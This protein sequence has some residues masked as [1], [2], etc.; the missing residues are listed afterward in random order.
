LVSFTD[1]SIDD[2]INTGIELLHVGPF[3]QAREHS[4]LRSQLEFLGS[5]TIK[6]LPQFNHEGN[7]YIGLSGVQAN[8]SVCLLF[9][10]AEG[11]AD[12]KLDKADLQWSTLCDNYWKELSVMDFIFDTTNDFLTSGVIKLIIPR[13]ATTD[14][15]IMPGDLIWFKVSIPQSNAV[16]L[17]IDVQSNA[18]IAEFTDQGNDPN[19]LK[20]PLAPN[21]ISKLKQPAGAIKGI[22][23]PYTSFGGRMQENDRA[24]YTRVSERLRHKERTITSWDYERLIL[25]HFPS[26]YKVKCI[27][28]ASPDSFTDAGHTLLVVI[29]DLTNQFSIDPFQPRVDKNTLDMILQLLQKHSTAWATHHVVNPFYEPVKI[30]LSVKLKRGFEFNY[31]QGEINKALQQF[32]SP[33]LGGGTTAIR[34][35]GKVT[36]SHIVKLM[37]DLEYVDYIENLQLFQSTDE[38]V[39]FVQVKQFAE[40]SGPASIL[41]SHTSHDI[42]QS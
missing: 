31:Y 34:F 24:F 37:E 17:M 1:D 8:D 19:H 38:G 36:E 7:F 41:V 5:N 2:F 15:T 25:Q 13:E 26:V 40:V 39:H 20:D 14:N 10:V 29:P 33:W 9:Q 16:C 22:T 3:G 35:G 12:P 21:T 42:S 27:N 11:S 23:Q 6:L 4:Y 28:H 18:A 30:S 32:L